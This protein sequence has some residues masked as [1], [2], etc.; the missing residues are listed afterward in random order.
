[1]TDPAHD[2][3]RKNLPD[4]AD[5]VA[6][7]AAKVLDLLVAAMLANILP[8]VGMALGFLYLLAGDGLEGGRSLGKRL[9]SLRVVDTETTLPATVRQSV[10]RNGHLAMLY[11]LVFIPILGYILAFVLGVFIMAVEL[12]AIFRDPNGLRMGDMFAETIVVGH[13]WAKLPQEPEPESA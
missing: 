4:A 10:L 13:S 6:R 8:P 12:H 2:P 7:I 3:E 5:P 11:G 9:V 1:M